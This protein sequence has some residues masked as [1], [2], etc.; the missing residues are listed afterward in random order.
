MI[1]PSG[2]RKSTGW[3]IASALNIVT[4]ARGSATADT[5]KDWCARCHSNAPASDISKNTPLLPEH[6]SMQWQM[7]EFISKKR[8]PLPRVEKPAQTIKGTTYFDAASKSMTEIYQERCIDIFESGRDFPCQFLSVGPVTWLIKFKKNVPSSCCKWRQGPFWA[9]RRD[10]VQNMKF[11]REQKLH[12]KS[13]NWWILNIPLPGPF[14]YGF[15]ADGQP[16]AF[17]F[18]VISGWVQ[19]E[20]H[21]FS[22]VRPDPAVFSVP[23]ICQQ[24]AQVCPQ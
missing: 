22:P 19:Q 11:D 1:R 20:F 18:P 9:P 12:G 2:L 8:P 6:F 4:V 7:H 5:P 13:V 23:E 3:V 17:W 15:H 24:D 14:G 16:A 21:H 10:V